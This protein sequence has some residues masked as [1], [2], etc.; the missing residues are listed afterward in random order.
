MAL[1]IGVIA[2]LLAV[3]LVLV[4]TLLVARPRD[5]SARDVLRLL[6]D[7]VRLVRRL[8][9]DPSLPRGVRVGLWLLLG[10]L[11]MPF[12]VVPDV[13]PVVGHMDD[14]IVVALVLRGVV[15]RAGYAALERHWPGTADGLRT[16]ARVSRV[17]TPG[18]GRAGEGNRTPV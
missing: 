15:R 10:Y 8:A 5:A 18:E 3:W 11:A 14:V 7:T 12:D 13:I 4:V 17:R 2:S 9:A 6:P 1:T 16:L